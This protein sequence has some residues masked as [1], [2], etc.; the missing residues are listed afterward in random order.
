MDEVMGM[1]RENQGMDKTSMVLYQ[2]MI[3]KELISKFIYILGLNG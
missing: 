2:I 1:I 3:S